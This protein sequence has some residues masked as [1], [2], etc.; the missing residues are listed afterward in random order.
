MEGQGSEKKGERSYLVRSKTGR[1]EHY[2]SELS[3]RSPLLPT[4]FLAPF[5]EY[6]SRTFPFT[7][8]RYFPHLLTDSAAQQPGLWLCCG[9]PGSHACRV[10]VSELGSLE[11]R[12]VLSVLPSAR[13]AVGVSPLSSSS[14]LSALQG[15]I[16]PET[17]VYLWENWLK[18]ANGFEREAVVT[19]TWG[20]C[21]FFLR[22][23]D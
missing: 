9:H 8:S 2:S 23:S 7:T 10:G 11:K 13:A 21:I 16:A 15:I 22:K 3:S 20:T 4:P 12:W 6:F 19:C 18:W 1:P 17:S 5:R 14:S